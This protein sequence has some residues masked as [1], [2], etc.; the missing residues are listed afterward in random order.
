[1]KKFSVP[2]NNSDPNEY[3]KAVLEYEPYIDH[4]Y[5]SLP[6]IG[7]SFHD[8]SNNI[9]NFNDLVNLNNNTYEFLKL[10]Q[11]KYKRFLVINTY[12]PF[13]NK[14]ERFSVL[15]KL[16]N[17]IDQYGLE[18]LITTDILLANFIHTERPLF[19]ICTSCNSW[20]YDKMSMDVWANAGAT[21]FNPPRDSIKKISSLK[22][23][24]KTGYKLKYLINESCVFG[25]PNKVNHVF[26]G[27]NFCNEFV[28][29]N[30]L[31]GMY[32]LPRW[33]SKLDPYVDIYKLSG[34]NR[35]N[36]FIKRTLQIYIENVNDAYL[37]E[38]TVGGFKNLQNFKINIKDIPDKLLTCECFDCKNCG[39]CNKLMNDFK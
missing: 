37:D 11:N 8:I 13:S 5:F 2:Y 28:A 29:E 9:S 17:L 7:R 34:R 31:K 18:G 16:L 20:L 15:F 30:Y 33:L 27:T 19:E 24:R 25:C 3:L 39:I 26:C 10:T 14:L 38:F 6:E 1:M 21:L 23:F 35:S 22:Y 36:S 4:F 12:Q 32:I